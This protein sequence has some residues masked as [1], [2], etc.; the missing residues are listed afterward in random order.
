MLTDKQVLANVGANVRRL[1][2][3]RS[4]SWLAE[5]VGTYPIN[6]SRIENATNM[7]N[8]G[9]LYRIAETLGTSVDALLS[10]DATLHVQAD[11]SATA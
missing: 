5:Q 2:G 8:I 7:P 1:R 10:P 4:L 3:E 11:T 9:I 6:I